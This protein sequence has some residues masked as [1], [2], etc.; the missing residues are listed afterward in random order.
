MT[1]LSYFCGFFLFPLPKLLFDLFQKLWSFNHVDACSRKDLRTGPDRFMSP[2]RLS[3]IEIFLRMR[4][5]TIWNLF[6]FR[7]STRSMIAS[8][9]TVVSMFTVPTS[10]CE[11][12]E[13]PLDS[14]AFSKIVGP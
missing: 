10:T 2:L 9:R 11:K 13:S 7:I 4:R 8:A 1:I 3:R 5:G 6:L 12:S 14:P